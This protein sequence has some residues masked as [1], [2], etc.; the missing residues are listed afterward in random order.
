MGFFFTPTRCSGLA[1]SL[2][3]EF[4]N[5]TPIWFPFAPINF[6]DP[7]APGRS[8][9]NRHFIPDPILFGG[10]HE[11][12]RR[13]GTENVAAIIGL[14]EADRAICQTAGFR[15]RDF[16]SS[17]TDRLIDFGKRSGRR[18]VSRLSN[19]RGW[20]TPR[21]SQWPVA[22]ASR[23]WPGWTL[24]VFAPRAVRLVRPARWNRRTSCSAMGV[25][26]SLANSL[27]SFFPWARFNAGGS[28]KRLEAF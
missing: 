19:D 26:K 28:S 16:L 7:R 2:F 11:N 21:L 5:S 3:K 20:P 12:E 25:E 13:A 17:L 22:T 15:P 9:S 4:T 6:T 14:A 18:S 1:R 10:W 27:G 23:C 24:K 8:S